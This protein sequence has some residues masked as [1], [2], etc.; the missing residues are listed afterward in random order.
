MARDLLPYL[1]L[2]TMI[3]LLRPL[4]AARCVAMLLFA[5]FVVAGEAQA[6]TTMRVVG[7]TS[8]LN[9]GQTT[10]F[11]VRA[12]SPTVG[13]VPGTY[14]IP[15]TI[16]GAN[17]GDAADYEFVADASLV[18]YESTGVISFATLGRIQIRLTDDSVPEPQ[19]SLTLQISTPTGGT[20]YPLHPTNNAATI[21]INPSDPIHIGFAENSRAVA[22]REGAGAVTLTVVISSPGTATAIERDAFSL[23]VSTMDGTAT[24]G[25]DYVMITEQ[26]IGPFGDAT[27]SQSVTITIQDD[28]APERERAS[29]FSVALSFPPGDEP[30]PNVVIEDGTTTIDIVD[31]DLIRIGF[32]EDSLEVPE[33]AGAVTLT[34][35]I[36][37]VPVSGGLMGRAAF[38]LVA[39]TM[40]GTADGNDYTELTNHSVGPFSDATRSLDVAIAIPDDMVPEGASTFSVALSFP[41]GEGTPADI[42]IVTGTTTIS[43][44]DDDPVTLGFAEDSRAVMWRESSG[45]VTLT[46]EITE[47]AADEPLEHVFSIV[48]NPVEGTADGGDDY[49]VTSY[50]VG[51]FSGATR[52]VSVEIA[53]E[54]DRV[55]EEAET[56]SVV[57]SLPSGAADAGNIVIAPTTAT[58]TI[59]D[60]DRVTV[61]FERTSYVESEDVGQFQVCVM[62]TNP[63]LSQPLDRTFPVSVN[64][65]ESE[66]T[67]ADY[68]PITNQVVGPFSDA[69]RRECFAVGITNDTLIENTERFRL[70]LS[71]P[72]G[73]A[74][75]RV[76]VN[77]DMATV[78]IND[79]EELLIGWSDPAL[80]VF[81]GDVMVVGTVSILSTA[82][83]TRDNIFVIAN[84]VDGTAFGSTDYVART[85]QRIG[86]FSSDTRS[87]PVEIGLI[88]RE[89]DDGSRTFSVT[90]AAAA[91]SLPLTRNPDTLTITIRDDPVRVSLVEP[92]PGALFI[93]A[94]DATTP[95][96]GLNISTPR[97]AA[98][99]VLWSITT[100]P[101]S[102][103]SAAP[104]DF[105]GHSSYPITG[106]VVVLSTTTETHLFDLP[107][108]VEYTDRDTEDRFFTLTLT[109]ASGGGLAA[110]IITATP[111]VVTLG[112]AG[113]DTAPP[114]FSGLSWAG[115]QSRVWLRANEDLA[116]LPPSRRTEVMTPEQLAASAE[117]RGFALTVTGSNVGAVMVTSALYHAPRGIALEL[118]RELTVDDGGVFAVY[119]YPGGDVPGIFDRALDVRT[120]E[121]RNQTTQTAT[122]TISYG[123]M[124]D[125]DSDG[126]P[127]AAEARIGSNPLVAALPGE[128]PAFAIAS[129]RR[130]SAGT[131]ALIAYSGIREY[132]ARAHLGVS[133]VLSTTQTAANTTVTQA[134]ATN[135]Q[136]YYLSDTFGYD[137]GYADI[138][139]Y[140]CTGEFPANY[141]AMVRAGGCETVD[142]SNVIAN[143]EHRIGWLATTGENGLWAVD[144]ATASNLPE[145]FIQRVPEL[146][147]DS[148]RLF[149]TG[150]DVVVR[151]A[152]DST[153]IAATT[154]TLELSRIPVGSTVATAETEDSAGTPPTF[155]ITS[156]F[157]IPA[158]TGTEVW[159]IT[160]LRN[161]GGTFR[162]WRATTRSSPRMDEYSLGLSTQTVVEVVPGADGFPPVVGRPQLTCNGNVVNV[163]VTGVA[164]TLELPVRVGSTPETRVFTLTAPDDV[165]ES[166]EVAGSGDTTATVMLRY[167]VVAATDPLAT[168]G[169]DADND[170]IAD[171]HD[172]YDD[173]AYLPVAVSLE[174]SGTA[175][176]RIWQHIRPVFSGQGLRI[177]DSSLARAVTAG[178]TRGTVVYNDYAASRFD[179]LPS[180]LSAVYDFSVFGVDYAGAGDEGGLAGVIIPLPQARYDDSGANL[181]VKYREGAAPVNFEATPGGNDYGFAPLVDG[182]CPDDTGAVGSRYRDDDGVL[183]RVKSAGDACL[184]VYVVDGGDYDADGAINSVVKDPLGLRAGAVGGGG[185]RHHSGGFGLPAL[186][187]LLLLLLLASGRRGAATRPS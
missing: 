54:N 108:L 131:P 175:G 85:N 109:G 101:A 150:N 65:R 103:N 26:M 127:D 184:V 125:A 95:Q 171:A 174:V 154:L 162:L 153:R 62:V 93:A 9:E 179:N 173:I 144:T 36:S 66:A 46:V 146:N 89:T 37:D 50:P 142:W 141:A 104:E 134:A 5:A 115:G 157:A 47:P 91:G 21:T 33:G 167:P 163:L 1:M 8:G 121:T 17:G 20:V 155:S 24:G 170:G 120:N 158:T 94:D 3:F 105:V 48:A 72:S 57:L 78:T 145:Q 34:V 149:T 92:E 27:R 39:N 165:P 67:N 15:F 70:E 13:L 181:V 164:C 31:D 156:S 159:Q 32:E 79:D 147:M 172:P 41:P 106:A 30:P 86:P 10:T 23:V 64:T 14:M 61:G 75:S 117:V 25:D 166:I 187:A 59:E 186:A 81:E 16:T 135:I 55:P 73:Q 63:P 182:A 122:I 168:A 180:G 29:T 148:Q 88:D 42:L 178:A 98:T 96:A 76:D 44:V 129:G 56:F 7:S 35:V 113:R 71:Q 68:N 102:M 43:I 100:G 110:G 123:V 4:S 53:I 2:K 119:E 45:T 133:S 114:R 176:A 151:A 97:G 82:M 139:S 116:I 128:R 161:A 22:V 90:L 84:T 6:Q 80:A 58:I 28:M 132:G 130:G 83:L 51:P 74:L 143:V 112:I 60:E 118:A 40:A 160:G 177:G 38:S 140:G 107:G 124:A 152:F 111:S 77:P 69:R 52:S 136:A 183:R 185:R 126:I 11:T 99:T 18:S 87:L 19:E 169:G 138:S 137:G 49:P 12:A